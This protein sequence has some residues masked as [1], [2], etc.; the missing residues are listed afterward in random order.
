M[1]Q[2]AME[3]MQI[4]P[5]EALNGKYADENRP[6]QGIPTI[7]RT[8]GG[9]LMAAWYS[10]GVT[11]NGDNFV[12]LYESRDNGENWQP[13]LAVDR[14]GDKVRAFDPDVWVDPQ[15][16]LW[17]FWAQCYD[18]TEYGGGSNHD[19]RGGVWCIR[20][21]APDTLPRQFSAPRRIA[22]GIMM[23]KPTVLSDGTWLF[24]TAVWSCENPPAAEEHPEVSGDRFSNVLATTDGGKTFTM[25]GRADVPNR[26]FD[27]H[28]IV[29]RRDGSLWM[30]VRCF[31]GIGQAIS[32]DKGV[33]WCREGHSGIPNPNSRSFLRR[34]RSG[35]LLLVHHV[36]FDGRNNLTARLSMDDGVSWTP[37]LLLDERRDVSYPDGTQAEDGSIYI[38]YDHDRYGEREILMAK[39][40]EQDILAGHI[41]DPRSRLRIPVSQARGKR[42]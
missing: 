26:E 36:N 33:T 12:L 2:L 18:C 23:N 17:L 27:E 16:R 29:E 4:I 32:Y 9:T 5:A 22:D 11:E 6:F 37:G 41:E 31:D 3:P 28:M 13:V 25:R 21:D 30:I 38:A 35:N 40:T 10:G 8:P 34:L 39:F 7:A 14:P 42:G 24:P 19:G 20:C 15:G 1:Y